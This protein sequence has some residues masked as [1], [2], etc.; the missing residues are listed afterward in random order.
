VRA[1]PKKLAPHADDIV[2]RYLAGE[3]TSTLAR[4]Y[5]CNPDTVRQVLLSRGIDR[6][7]RGQVPGVQMPGSKLPLP[8]H[9]AAEYNAGATLKALGATYCVSPSTVRRVLLRLGITRRGPNRRDPMVALAKKL[10]R[11][12]GASA[13]RAELARMGLSVSPGH[14]G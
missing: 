10:R 5:Q 2:A 11:C 13:A 8:A 3:S 9:L 7:P 6:R 12:L 14:G 1:S 4:S